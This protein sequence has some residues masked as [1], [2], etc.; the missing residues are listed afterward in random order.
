MA[1]KKPS[2][3]DLARQASAA[4]NRASRAKA[5]AD[6]WKAEAKTL[7]DALPASYKWDAAT[8]QYTN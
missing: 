1:S 3:A 4:K 8:G 2:A 6:Y 7:A 5:S